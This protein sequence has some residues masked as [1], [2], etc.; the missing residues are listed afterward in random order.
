MS[1]N[2]KYEYVAIDFE[3]ANSNLTSACAIGIVCAKNGKVALDKYYL[4]NPEEPFSDFNISIHHITPDM[5]KDALT[6]KELWSEIRDII[7]GETVVC[8]NAMFDIAVLKACLEKYCLEFP[9]ISIGC[10]VKVSRIAYKGILPNCK[11]NTISNYLEVEH[12]HHNASSDAMVCYYLVERVKRMY[13]AIDIFELFEIINL[14]FGVLNDHTYRGCFN[15]YKEKVVLNNVLN[16]GVFSSTGKPKAMT[17]TEFR[18]K[19]EENGG[20]YSK[21]INKGINSFVIFTNPEKRKLH[22]LDVLKEHKM[23]NIY[24]EEEFIEMLK[25]KKDDK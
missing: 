21:D 7:D 25:G 17:K 3:T 9:S 8:H 10:T 19:V 15:K 18:K 11:L 14:G 20:Y 13:Q 1:L 16:G 24:N 12:N 5:V 2:N 6:F 4:I 23:I 22:E